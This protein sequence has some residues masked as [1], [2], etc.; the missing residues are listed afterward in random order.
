MVNVDKKWEKQEEQTTGAHNMMMPVEQNRTTT[1]QITSLFKSLGER[2][3]MRLAVLGE[4]AEADR[5]EKRGF[6]AVQ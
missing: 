5:C 2:A 6:K 4:A 3:S 1:L